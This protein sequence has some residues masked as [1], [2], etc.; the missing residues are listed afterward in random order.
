MTL[1]R[2][3][4]SDIRP[5]DLTLDFYL[6]ATPIGGGK[7]I[8]MT[9]IESYTIGAF[10]KNLGFGITSVDIDI[11]PSLQPV[12]SITFK[13]LYGN[14][15]FND[16]KDP[17]FTFNYDVLFQL[18][19]PKFR[20]Y[21]KGYLG[22]PVSF[23][24]QVKSV[25]TTFVP[26]DGSYEIK[27]EFVPN[28]FGFFNDI[29]YQFL[30]AVKELK[31][32][33]GDGGANNSIIDIAKVGK[34]IST[35]VQQVTDKYGPL[36]SQ[37]QSISAGYTA[38]GSAF[39]DGTLKIDPI[40]GDTELIGKG[41][42]SI[43]FNINT[44]NAK[45]ETINQIP[46]DQLE[47]FGKSIYLSINSTKTINLNDEFK[48]LS[49]STTIDSAKIQEANVKKILTD[50]LKIVEDVSQQQAYSNVEDKFIDT[51]SIFNVMTRLAGDCAYVLGYILEGGLAG[52]NNKPS[53]VS[54]TEIFGN[55][56]PL[57]EEKNANS[58]SSSLGQQVP[59][60]DAKIE[61]AKVEEFVKS[62]YTGKQEAEK[63]IEEVQAKNN[64]TESADPTQSANY[65]S[66]IK[67]IGNVETFRP[68]SPYSDK[69][70]NIIVNL[71]QRAGMLGSGF[72]S[73]AVNTRI[74]QFTFAE[75]DNV[76]ELVNKLKGTEK[77]TLKK[78]CN[79]IRE[80]WNEKGEF[81]SPQKFNSTTSA[82][83]TLKSY[84]AGYF[85]KFP[86]ASETAQFYNKDTSTL[87]SVYTYNNDILY[88]NPKSLRDAATAL[89]GPSTNNLFNNISTGA[90]IVVYYAPPNGQP[91]AGSESLISPNIADS[92]TF[93]P[94]MG[95]T[96]VPISGGTVPQTLREAA[97]YQMFRAT[98]VV[99]DAKNQSFFVDYFKLLGNFTASSDG[100]SGTYNSAYFTP[101][102]MFIQHSKNGS[103]GSAPQAN[104]I[105]FRLLDADVV[106]N[107]NISSYVIDLDNILTR[108]YLYTFCTNILSTKYTYL[109]LSEA[110]VKK[111]Q[112]QDAQAA[113]ASGQG[114][115]ITDLGTT[116]NT[117]PQ[118]YQKDEA[119]INA[120]Y[121]QFHHICQ[122]WI[123]LAN[124]KD[125]WGNSGLPSG[126][127]SKAMNL[128]TELETAYKST[129]KDAFFYLNFEFPLAN[130]VASGVEIKDSLVNTDSLLENNAQTSTLNM[131][132]NICTTNNFLLQPI[133]GG[134]TDELEDIFLPHPD[135][136][137]G[138]GK[139]ALSIIW[140][141]TPENRLSDNNNNPIYPQDDFFD[142]LNKVNKPILCLRYGDPNN[143]IVKSI[144]AGTDDNK[145]TSESIQA[146]SDIVN[147]Q[148]QNKRKSF[149]CSML[150]V[151]Q[152]R[153]Y[154]ISLDLIGNA[155]LYPTQLIA[156]EGLPIF[157]GLYWITEVQ[158]KLTP[159]NMETT[160]NAVKMKYGG[161][162]N[163]SAVMPI[164]KRVLRSFDSGNGGGSGSSSTSNA[165][166]NLG[167]SGDLNYK[168]LQLIKDKKIKNTDDI[169]P[170]IYEFT[171]KKYSDFPTWFNSELAGNKKPLCGAKVNAANFK[172]VWDFLIPVVWPEY[173]TSGCN[174]LEF[175]ALHCIMYAETGGSYESK[176]EG[177]NSVTNEPHPG[178]AFAFDAYTLPAANGKEP[179][180]KASYNK[181]PNK[182]AGELFNDPNY[183][184]KFKNLKF[185]NDPKVVK[186]NDAAWKG[187]TFPKSL[188][189]N[190]QEAVTTSST[191]ISEADFYKFAGRGFIGSTWRSQYKEF[192]KFILTYS[193]SDSVVRKYQGNW[194]TSPFN[195]NE[196]IILTKSTNAD[197]D[198]LFTSGAI[199]GF[200]VYVHAKSS[201]YQYMNPLAKP[202]E[203]LIKAIEKEGIRVNGGKDY[204][205]VHRTR[206]YVI[207]DTLYPEGATVSSI[208]SSNSTAVNSTPVAAKFNDGKVV[209]GLLKIMKDKS[210]KINERAY[211]MNIVGVRSETTT[212]NSFDDRIYVFW[213]N[214]KGTWEG[215]D[216]AI[217]TDPGTYWLKNP[218]NVDG[219]AILKGGQWA[220]KVGTHR[221]EYKAMNQ[222]GKVTVLNDSDRNGVLDFLSTN[223]R[224]GFFGINIHRSSSVGTSNAVDKWSAGCQVF[225][226]I[227]NF[228]D[229]LSYIDR[230]V[231]SY[232]NDTI[233]YT[234]IDNRDFKRYIA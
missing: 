175:V 70:D 56:Y 156:V 66:L 96:R 136:D 110:E 116:E 1:V 184:D 39:K 101:Q 9:G 97:F 189:A 105:I 85:G 95:D 37:L 76:K 45:G 171:K 86:K 42:Q 8:S 123:A 60:P 145:V 167:Y 5:Q 137:Y 157:T 212:A 20:L 18:P 125:L 78:F 55:Y 229:F 201:K 207:L 216:Y 19:Y 151:M 17:D 77:E 6:E 172:K 190:V 119:E 89:G 174:F 4:D 144:K 165:T 74:N 14:L 35:K 58:Q 103:Q 160:I 211:E 134:I 15:V 111:K 87:K 10:E 104:D 168:F 150:A 50:N 132:Q 196:E 44:K 83:P 195:G 141:P 16:K 38:I 2:T 102:Q 117:G 68:N 185:G 112:V 84:L 62:L 187:T 67:K 186:S 148:N 108:Q 47:V 146:T 139:N 199:Q 228:R 214:D 222:R 52:F 205:R 130:Q 161:R 79:I 217:T 204:Q 153:S 114:G 215:S 21:V 27:A 109:N 220:Y 213:K 23:L 59:D 48:K 49:A 81:K 163:F 202:K 61:L 147:N 99:K 3:K 133:P 30:F 208:S 143:I 71:I 13:D 124:F 54:N 210:Y 166:E 169:N 115:R 31:N 32:I 193:G 63:V 203:E 64:G 180:S 107:S 22:K 94:S 65:G 57:I 90:E 179:R 230:H 158:H 191:F 154:S 41:F 234:L 73:S 221:G 98:D 24:L 12:V 33:N 188:F 75:I 122:A 232:G 178:I 7:S 231:K 40:P 140:S 29:P 194:K 200:A 43:K 181:S 127:D 36:I 223:E 164:T 224:T 142:K 93:D 197:W 155:Q 51:Q 182:T 177:M 219:T 82:G 138:A 92:A 209:Q 88:H 28:V 46:N 121:T 233:L 129:N 106:N 34:E 126:T 225:A 198:E 91:V 192:V 206:V 80:S 226:N 11:K 131:M 173:G 128:R 152:G 227:Q 176:H 113:A 69:A 162:D 72:G 100:T 135:L 53:R 120:I 183:I 218:M 159:N 26:A 25:K 149:D 170:I 118:P